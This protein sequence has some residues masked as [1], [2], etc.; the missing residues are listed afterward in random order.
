MKIPRIGPGAVVT[1]NHAGGAGA[2]FPSASLTTT[3]TNSLVYAVGVDWD[4]ARTPLTQSAGA[5][6]DAEFRPAVG[7]TYWVQRTTAPVASPIGVTLGVTY[8]GAAADR[9]NM[10][11]IEIRHP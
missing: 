2:T 10:A 3:A 1:A 5:T 4:A 7:D 8:G 9:W 6:S 11:I